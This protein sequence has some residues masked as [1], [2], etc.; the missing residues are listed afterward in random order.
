MN[1]FFTALL[2]LLLAFGAGGTATAEVAIFTGTTNW[3]DKALADEQAQITVD[4]LSAAGVSTLWFSN[5]GDVA[6][7]TALAEWVSGATNN[8]E[9]DVLILYG[10]LPSSLY[11]AGNLAPDGSPAEL[12][13]ESTD[14]D[15]I[16]NHADWMFYVST[17]LNTA[18]GLQNIMDVPG[19]TMGPDNTPMTVTA[20]GKDIAHSLVDFLSDRPFHV[21]ELAG[22]WFVE[23]SLAENPNGT[24][25]DP[26]IL[27]DGDLGRLIPIHQAAFQ[28]DPKGAVAAEVVAW[29]L[30][31][32]LQPTELFLAG[33]TIT[34]TGTPA[35]LRVS[36]ADASAVPT[37]GTGELTVDLASDSGTGAFDTAWGG[38]YDGSVTSVTIPAG[39]SSTT[40]YYRDSNAALVTLSAT[41]SGG[42]LTAAQQQLNVLEDVSGANGEVAIYTGTT[43]WITKGAADQQAA[44]CSG[45]LDSLGI[46][47]T[48]FADAALDD[49]ALADWVTNATDNGAVDVLILYGYLPPTLYE[50]GNTQPDG[51]VA[52]VFI[53]ST[54]GDVIINHADYMFY[55]SAPLNE[56]FGLQ[57]IMDIPSITMWDNDTPVVVTDVGASI[58]PSLADFLSDRPFHVDELEGEWFVEAALAE[59]AAGTRADPIIVR[60]GNRG[61]LV[62]VFQTN[63]QNDPKG[64]VA[65]EIIASL[66]DVEL[67]NATQVGIVGTQVGGVGDSL[68]LTVQLQDADGSPRPANIATTVNL[69]TSSAGGDFDVS[70]DGPFDGSVTSVTVAAGTSSAEFYY[71]DS[72]AG[73]PTLTA[74]AAGLTSGGIEVAIVES[75]FAPAGEVMLWTGTTNWIDKALADAQAAI[76]AGRLENA[77]VPNQWL[78]EAIDDVALAEW[79]E[80]VT[81]NGRLDVLVLYGF[82]PS[83]IYPGGNAEPDGSIAERFIESTD[84][85][86]IINHADWMFYV[87]ETLNTHDGLRNMM[88][89]PSVTMGGPND[90]PM[91]VT[92]EGQAIAPTLSDFLSDRPLHLNSLG[93]QWYVEVSLA[94]S[95]DGTLAD[96]VLIRDGH[97]GRL[98]PLFQANAQNDPKGSVAAEV[99]AWLM[100]AE[101]SPTRLGLAGTGAT[102][103]DTPVKFTVSI[104]DEGG[105]ALPADED[106][107]V[108]LGTTSGGGAFDESW[109]G[110][111][112][113][114]TTSVLIAAGET[115]AS[116]YYRDTVAGVVT[117]TAS[118][119]GAL[120]L[121]NAESTVTVLQDL[122]GPAGEVAIY[123]GNV[124]WI[125]PDLANA[126]AQISVDA[127]TALGISNTW[128][129]GPLDTEALLEW[130]E[131][132]TDNGSVDVLVLYGYFPPALYAAPNLEPDGSVAELFIESTDGDVIL[133]HADYMFYVSSPD[134]SS[135]NEVGGLQNM[136]DNFG[137]FMWGDNT[138]MVVTETGA[139]I[140]PSL[141]DFA[142][143]RPFHVDELEGEWFV[144]AALAEDPSGTRV[145]PAIVRDGNRG[146]LAT[147][148]Q[149]A[150]DDDA[151]GA[152]AAEMIAWLLGSDPGGV[153]PFQRGDCN[154]DGATNLTDGVFLLN[155]LFLGGPPPTCGAACDYNSDGSLNITT[156]VFIFNFLFL[157]G[158]APV[159]PRIACGTS[160]LA[161]DVEIGCDT[162]TQCP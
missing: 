2:A 111:F 106:V 14:G 133:N 130:V 76:C 144:E 73:S 50:G 20:A 3:I 82:F 30:G 138:P 48:L 77:D 107:V 83:A 162:F 40:V 146:R 99:I 116:F 154:D 118:D 42:V 137:I 17:P 45:I 49:V 51:S 22:N 29:L 141:V 113:G 66:F 119:P 4:R 70:S 58:A 140:A 101:F 98:M 89:V 43:G 15:A 131:E 128:F 64:A 115:S 19:I 32:S 6:D 150:F 81:D 93:G 88:D 47:H 9:L 158:P 114:T 100:S 161:T 10:Y 92:A 160:M 54:D 69:A 53:E 16:I 147:A 84:G 24:R 55:V 33:A 122:S 1:R 28:N 68:Q 90:T 56:V 121:I 155:F 7:E 108:T 80:G 95:A 104:Q 59:N 139:T 65:A 13:I 44:I 36:R 129:S 159:G 52:E 157:G 67:S 63:G 152:V 78:S 26:I 57:N 135:N 46:S 123:T 85:D 21:D 60:D 117:I 41:D 27:R 62:P 125:D 86:V 79:V 102:V 156:G 124:N 110:D 105:I 38:S 71:Q 11:E 12:F 142:S 127:L 35:K 61:R 112:D 136:M 18:L 91:V 103:T 23:A 75:T 109:N 34:V 148:F 37:P 149:T 31:E 5:P 143:D 153:G 132:S 8:G 72:A 126:Q 151:K 25:A 87:A 145:D 120:G 94:E 97:R 134:G 39:E 74:S 96:P